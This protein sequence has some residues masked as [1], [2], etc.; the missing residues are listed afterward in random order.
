MKVLHVAETVRGG[1]ATYLSELRPHQRA[2]Y[3]VGNVHYLVPSDHR[4]D[5]TGFEDDEVFV[6]RR[7]GRS[8]SSLFWMALETMRQIRALS[9]DVVHI[10]STFAG[11]AIR[12]ILFLQR[13][14]PQV[15]YCPHGWAFS[16]ETSK[17]SRQI[18][19]FAE[20][21]LSKVTDRIICISKNELDNAIRARIDET[22]LVVVNNGIALDRPVADPDLFEWPSKKLKVLFIGR[23]DKQKG[24]DILLETARQLQGEIEVRIIG[25]SVV[26][27]SE[28]IELPPNVTLLGWMNQSQIEANL[29]TTDLVVI[30]SRWE[31]FG[32]VALEAMRAAKPIVAF[33]IGALP[34][35]VE[36]QE[37]GILCEPVGVSELT[38]ALKSCLCLDLPT[39]GKRGYERFKRLYDVEKTFQE[40][41]RIYADCCKHQR[42]ENDRRNTLT[43]ISKG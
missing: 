19:E 35:I 37:T 12:P 32:L 24:Y 20:R 31:A 7:L 22:R 15:V 33:R 14:G 25:T 28:N 39:I 38:A 10:H 30:P 34:E 27:K 17:L 13:G 21:L 43:G 9:P 4:H 5:L 1:I 16:R 36:D 3:G 40:L 11:L 42:Q 41:D 2:R 6:F 29:Q 23:L 18:T 8:V 26:G